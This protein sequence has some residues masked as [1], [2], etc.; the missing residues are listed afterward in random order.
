MRMYRSTWPSDFQKENELLLA[1]EEVKLPLAR[2]VRASAAR[3]AVGVN[4]NEPYSIVND[5]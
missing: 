4:L 1:A 2:S 5:F 3:S